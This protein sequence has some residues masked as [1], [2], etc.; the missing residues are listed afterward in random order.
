[1]IGQRDF[2]SVVVIFQIKLLGFCPL[3]ELSE[4]D[5]T[6]AVLV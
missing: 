5:L 2:S 1:M 3:D 6:S 4:Q